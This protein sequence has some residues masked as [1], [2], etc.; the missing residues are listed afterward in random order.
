MTGP[1]SPT[2][3]ASASGVP[4]NVV[5]V[6][7]RHWNVALTLEAHSQWSEQTIHGVFGG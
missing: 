1:K 4:F 5:A 7:M 6:Q 3:S 2:P